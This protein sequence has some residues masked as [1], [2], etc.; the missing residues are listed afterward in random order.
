MSWLLSGG[1]VL[2]S[3]EVATNRRAR[4]RGLLG[5]A[6]VD[7][8]FVIPGCTWIHTIG[9]RFPIDVAYLDASGRVLKTVRMSRHRLGM[10]VR[11]ASTIVEAEAGAFARWGLQTGD[12]VEI[13]DAERAA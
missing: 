4:G 1:R 2:A 12:T 9:M 13:R 3:A 7:G 5:R 8:A 10:P 6:G 11:Q